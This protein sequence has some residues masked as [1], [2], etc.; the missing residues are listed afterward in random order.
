MQRNLK[1]WTHDTLTRR[2][3]VQW[4]AGLGIGAIP[5]AARLAVGGTRTRTNILRNLPVAHVSAVA[6]KA[7][8]VPGHKPYKIN[9]WVFVRT[10]QYTPGELLDNHLGPTFEMRRN[11]P[12]QV[13]WSNAIPGMG[14]KSSLLSTPP[15]HPTPSNQMCGSSSEQSPVGIAVHLHGAR[16][17]SVADGFPLIPLGFRGNPYGFATQARYNYANTQRATMLWYHDHSMDNSGKN[18]YAGLVGSYFLRDEHDDRIVQMIG[19]ATQEMPLVLQDAV[20]TADRTG[21]DYSA[22]TAGD[23]AVYGRLARDEVLGD[24][25]FVNGHPANFANLPMR[26]NVFRWRLLSATNA[27]TFA[28]ALIDPDALH[29]GRGRIWYS[30]CMRIIGADGGLLGRS[31]PLA[32]LDVLLLASAQRRDVL[33]DL[34]AL[35]VNVNRLRLVNLS[36]LFKLAESAIGPE[37]LYSTFSESVLVPT[38]VTYTAQDQPL[39]NALAQLNIASV[40]N[41]SLAPAAPG[42]PFSGMAV[43]AVLARAASDDDFVWNGSALTLPEQAVLGPNRLVLALSDT[44]E[45]DELPFVLPPEEV[46][47]QYGMHLAGWSE[48]Q[49]FEMVDGGIAPAPDNGHWQLPFAIDLQT[50]SN[51]PPGEAFT[52]N[53]QTTYTIGRRSFFQKRS[54]PDITVARAYPVPHTPVITPRAGT[55]E[56]WYVANI[57][58]TQIL[59]DAGPAPDMHPLHIHLVNF[60]VTRRWQ[61]QGQLFVPV[62]AT[63]LALDVIARQDTVMIPSNHL[64]ELLVFYP[65]GYEGDYL[66]HCHVLEHENKCMMSSFRVSA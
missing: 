25:L 27:R 39:Y 59:S 37:A 19:G 30:D 23:K 9:A 47:G 1:T 45:F 33:V 2:Q 54:N 12:L 18:V 60:V 52:D 50:T 65:P 4:V 10:A 62:A 43:D 28:L 13:V 66:Y 15:V 38:S 34:S 32:A 31:V 24:T 29:A 42:T 48:V 14:A 61:L 44:N 8:W 55:Y 56:R 26:R 7:V 17:Q 41:I 11:T 22:A 40:A 53:R 21:V 49:L 36:L 35:A 51:P 16:V 46:G 5:I 57:G 64:L 63:D 20:L 3:W 6:A 58:N